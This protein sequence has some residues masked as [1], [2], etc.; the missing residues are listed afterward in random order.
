MIFHPKLTLTLL[1]CGVD[2]W[3]FSMTI[4]EIMRERVPFWEIKTEFKVL[5]AVMNRRVPPRPQIP[6]IPIDDVMW[7]LITCTWCN[8]Q[9]RPTMQEMSM[10]LRK[11]VEERSSLRLRNSRFRPTN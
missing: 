6:E 1:I 5:A 4:Y 9:T 7:D 2:V 8:P 11:I 10:L 3:S